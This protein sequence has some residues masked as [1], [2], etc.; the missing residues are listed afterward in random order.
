MIVKSNNH[1]HF[2]TENN[3]V[4]ESYRTIRGLRFMEVKKL[5][6]NYPDH[7]KLTDSMVLFLNNILNN[8]N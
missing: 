3:I 4:Y 5:P 7:E 6:F 2:W 1:D 8:Q